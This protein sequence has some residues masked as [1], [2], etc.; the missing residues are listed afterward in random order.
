AW[1][2]GRE[3]RGIDRPVEH[4]GAADA[5]IFCTGTVDAEQ[6]ENVAVRVDEMVVHDMHRKRRRRFA[7][8]MIGGKQSRKQ[9]A[10][11]S[12]SK[13]AMA[14]QEGLR[15]QSAFIPWVCPGLAAMPGEPPPVPR[16][17]STS[18]SRTNPP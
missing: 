11:R 5:H 9:E 3:R 15:H 2:D 6:A 14:G 10:E 17:P 16:A 12:E 7:R 8:V 1:L 13:L 4:R 18:H